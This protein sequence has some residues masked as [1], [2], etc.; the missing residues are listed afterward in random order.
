VTSIPRDSWVNVPGHG[1]NKINAA[2]SYGGTALAVRTIEN[3]THVRID[4]VMIM[5]FSGF[6]DVTDAL[7]GVDITVPAATSDMR[8][9]FK[10]GAQ[11]MD[12]ATALNY[13]RERH[14]L[15]GGD[16]DREK[17][18]QNWIRAILTKEHD[19]GVAKDVFTLNGVLSSMTKSLSVD[20][21]FSLGTMRSLV[22][23]LRSLPTSHLTFMTAPVKG[24]GREGSQDVVFLDSG[25][26]QA[27][28]KAVS[29]D[30]VGSWL[31]AHPNAALGSTVR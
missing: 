8:A 17:R 27:L 28:W 11:H 30:R 13:V 26:N 12:G 2:F 6:K 3:Y 15:P 23:S 22:W 10:A 7:G 5:D 31:E 18:Q 20:D 4:H 25:A 16:F 21:T 14:G 1:M 9:S 29:G 19:Q 24:T